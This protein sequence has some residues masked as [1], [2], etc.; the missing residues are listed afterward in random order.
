MKRVLRW[1]PPVYALHV[2][3]KVFYIQVRS[4]YG[5]SIIFSTKFKKRQYVDFFKNVRYTV[6]ETEGEL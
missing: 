3:A 6:H 1:W 4:F 2:T 5:D